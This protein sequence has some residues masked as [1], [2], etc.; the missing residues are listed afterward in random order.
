MHQSAKASTGLDRSGMTSAL[1]VRDTCIVDYTT[2]KVALMLANNT[3][4]E[5]NIPQFDQLP[6]RIAMQII[7]LY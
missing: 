5:F 6:R 7:F 2:N 1:I 3:S 4:F